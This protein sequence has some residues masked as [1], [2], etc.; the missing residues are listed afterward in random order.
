MRTYRLDL[1][2]AFWLCVVIIFTFTCLATF[3]QEMPPSAAGVTVS[4]PASPSL[5]SALIPVAVP[6]LLAL[7]KLFVPKIPSAWLPILAPI[8]GAA[9]DL[10]LHFAAGTQLN[11]LVGA[12]LGSAGVGIREIQDQVRQRL[13]P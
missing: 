6:A 12:L 5:W 8:L 9:G 3:A 7:V 1:R 11:P 10:V 13:T 2:H 4:A